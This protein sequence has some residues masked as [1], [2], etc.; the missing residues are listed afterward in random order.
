MSHEHW[1]Q[2]IVYLGNVEKMQTLGEVVQKR[3]VLTPQAHHGAN[4]LVVVLQ[5]WQQLLVNKLAFVFRKYD[6][7]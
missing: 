3:S 4:V 6:V 5:F 7:L 1:H 2:G